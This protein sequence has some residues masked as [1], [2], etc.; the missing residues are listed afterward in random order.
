MENKRKTKDQVPKENPSKE[1]DFPHSR[2]IDFQVPR[3]GRNRHASSNFHQRNFEIVG[4]YNFFPEDDPGSKDIDLFTLDE[5]MSSPVTIL[6]DKRDNEPSDESRFFSEMSEQMEIIKQQ[7]NESLR[8]ALDK[9]ELVKK[10]LYRTIF[11]SKDSIMGKGEVYNIVR[12][13]LMKLGP[14]SEDTSNV[15]SKSITICHK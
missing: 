7:D 4:F 2:S 15:V 13:S 6:E 12:K 1:H 9:R 8:N 10:E 14:T 3:R 11:P 5:E